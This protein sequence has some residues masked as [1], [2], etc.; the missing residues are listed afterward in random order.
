MKRALVFDTGA[1]IAADRNDATVSAIVKA[2]KATDTT[3]YAPATC[4]AEAWRDGR[5][6]ARL[7]MFLKGIHQFPSLDLEDAKNVGQLLSRSGTA[8]VAD[9]H[10]VTV[11]VRVAPSVVVTSDPSDIETLLQLF[12][13]D[14][15]VRSL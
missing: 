14:V 10:L 1:L 15:K 9:A 6:Q 3:I 2:A 5:T 4:V 11:A 7:A 12:E 8:Q 13:R